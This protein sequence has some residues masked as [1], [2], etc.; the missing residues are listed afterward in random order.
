MKRFPVLG[1]RLYLRS[2]SINVCFRTIIKETFEKN[3][4]EKAIENVCMKHPFVN[5]CLEIDSENEIWLVQKNDFIGIEYHKSSEMDWQTWYKKADNN[6]F[7]FFHGPLVKFCVIVGRD[8]EI[9]ILG[10]HIIGDGIGYINLV[11]DILLALDNRLDT[12]PQIPPHAEKD[13]YFKST[14]LLDSDVQSFANNLN[15]EWRKT[16]IKFS[17][18]EYLDFFEQYRSKYIPSLYVA[19]VEGDNAKKILEKSKITGLTVNDLIA[20]AFSVAA[21]ETLN[22]KEIRLGVAAN[23]RNEIVSEPNDCMGNF[24]T[25]ISTKVYLDLLNDFISNAKA[26]SVLL[27]EQLLNPKNR[28]LIVHFLGEFDKDLIESIM[29]AA[30]GNF[31]HPVPKKLAELIGEQSENKGL[32]ISNL[33]RHNFPDY[34]NFSLMDIQFIIPAFPANLLTVGVITVNNK[35]N[36]CLG[37]NEGEIKIDTVKT[38]CGKAIE[39]LT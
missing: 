27:K 22:S 17:E 38:I 2:P 11:K 36:L 33:G 29:P 8:T 13:K 37:Y 12:N 6:V 10:H 16:R 19:S 14:F 34:N 23:I 9:I 4:I 31:N 39:L 28:H 21:M 20:S 1:E 18:K 5:S 25:G 35:F 15:D 24:A 7:D 3:Q 32:G 30:Y 26:I